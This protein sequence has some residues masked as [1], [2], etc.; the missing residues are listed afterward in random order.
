MEATQSSLPLHPA[1]EEALA[2]AAVEARGLGHNFIGTEHLL[3]G[4]LGDP[5]S[6]GTHIL[7][8][9]G[10]EAA[11]VRAALIHII[12]RH[13]PLGDEAIGLT[14]RT[15]ATMALAN[16][17]AIGLHR[18]QIT[19]EILLIGILREGEGIAAGIIKTLG[20]DLN[21]VRAQLY[22]TGEGLAAGLRAIASPD[23]EKA[24]AQVMLAAGGPGR[25]AEGA[26]PKPNVITCRIGDI[27]Q[28][29]LDALVEA[30]VRTSR[31]EAASWAIH[32]GLEANKSLLEK[33]YST[34]AEIRRLRAVAQAL[35]Q[36]EIRG[37][38]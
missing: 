14:P 4:L 33:V 37:E 1:T 34:V 10:I 6:Q 23:L 31:S 25:P 24:R 29:A 22:L 36:E 13:D 2:Q 5:Q 27:D 21:M 8:T 26:A 38:D 16:S 7:G 12:G 3:L 32:A 28:D 17:E 11:K 15:K 35:A 19:P 9:Y 18:P 20:A 30:G